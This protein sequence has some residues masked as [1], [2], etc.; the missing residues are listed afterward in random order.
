MY[1]VCINSDR[2]GV[3][4]ALGE[5]C[6]SRPKS[7]ESLLTRVRDSPFAAELRQV[8]V[9]NSMIGKEVRSSVKGICRW[10]TRTKPSPY[11][12]LIYVMLF[13][14]LAVLGGDG[15]RWSN[16]RNETKLGLNCFC[17]LPTDSGKAVAYGI[18]LP[19]KSRLP[20]TRSFPK[21]SNIQQYKRHFM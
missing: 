5:V 1:F 15:V 7:K 18:G 21:S 20:M 10:M 19:A 14:T 9:M 17:L 4:T 2:E 16:L 13:K 8:R 12:Y 6:L 3:K 11:G